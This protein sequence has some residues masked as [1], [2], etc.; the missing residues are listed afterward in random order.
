MPRDEGVTGKVSTIQVRAIEKAGELAKNNPWV[1]L[2]VIITM[3]G[4]MAT[5]TTL[6]YNKAAAAEAKADSAALATA[7]IEGMVTAMYQMQMAQNVKAGLAVVEAKLVPA[8]DTVF[9]PVVVSVD[10]TKT[11][12]SA[13]RPR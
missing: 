13:T 7:K 11:D 5:Q 8:K 12:S 2:S 9:V 1:M 6:L 3:V 10:T 4:G